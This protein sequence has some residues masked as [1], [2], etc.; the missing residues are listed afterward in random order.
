MVWVAGRGF[1]VVL[2]FLLLCVGAA[3]PAHPLWLAHADVLILWPRHCAACSIISHSFLRWLGRHKALDSLGC[4]ADTGLLICRAAA[5]PPR[6]SQSI[7]ARPSA[8]LTCQICHQR[9]LPETP[10]LH[11][12]ASSAPHTSSHEQSASWARPRLWRKRLS[13]TRRL[14]RCGRCLPAQHAAHARR[15]TASPQARP[16][17]A[18]TV[19]EPAS[20]AV[21]GAAGG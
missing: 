17:H 13:S 12:T 1:F 21:V 7:E 8:L 4:G 18:P 2:S 3:A 9:A 15:L 10:P 19:E 5:A 16:R 11:R 14:S 20:R 6:G